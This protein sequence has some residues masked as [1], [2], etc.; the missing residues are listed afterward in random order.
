MKREVEIP[1][2]IMIILFCLLLLYITIDIYQG[3]TFS[4]KKEEKSLFCPYSQPPAGN[5]AIPMHSNS[6]LASS[7]NSS[8]DEMGTIYTVRVLTD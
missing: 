1:L 6:T 4:K 7:P 3:A 2:F 8:P 5:V